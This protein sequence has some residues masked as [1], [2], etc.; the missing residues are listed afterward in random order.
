MNIKKIAKRAACVAAAA[1]LFASSCVVPIQ[2]SVLD[3]EGI[4]PHVSVGIGKDIPQD[5]ME[6]LYK[7]VHEFLEEIRP[8]PH[9][10]DLHLLFNHQLEPELEAL[11]AA[12]H[13]FENPETSVLAERMLQLCELDMKNCPLLQHIPEEDRL[14][15]TIVFDDADADAT[16]TNEEGR[17][18]QQAKEYVEG[19]PD[20]KSLW[21]DIPEAPSN[22]GAVSRFQFYRDGYCTPPTVFPAEF[23]FV[24][25][26]EFEGVV[27][28]FAVLGGN[29][30][31]NPST[32]TLDVQK[33]QVV[34]S[35]RASSWTKE[36]GF[37]TKGAA[38]E[39]SCDF[40][41]AVQLKGKGIGYEQVLGI[42]EQKFVPTANT[43][44]YVDA[45]KPETYPSLK[46]WFE[47][48][49]DPEN[50]N[51]SPPD[52]ALSPLLLNLPLNIL[53]FLPGLA[54]FGK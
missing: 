44:I 30:Q 40:S 11:T 27:Y 22:F 54:V 39:K 49:I 29:A 19:N 3:G 50:P 12:Q 14:G 7:H 15:K 6:E 23:N 17:K 4:E 42:E 32:Q 53:S 26:T 8:G 35:K 5:I 9:E 36:G 38:V 43:P 37:T 31:W 1:G 25:R 10:D 52:I 24:P 47:C 34:Y 48:W 41:A 33:P 18:L 46:A 20:S 45:L 51:C 21:L 16:S 28:A 13:Y 2:A